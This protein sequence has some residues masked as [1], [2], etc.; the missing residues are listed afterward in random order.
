[1]SCQRSDLFLLYV[2]KK[3]TVDNATTKVAVSATPHS[4][5]ATISN[6]V[7]SSLGKAAA[8]V[9]INEIQVKAL[10]VVMPKVM[11]IPVL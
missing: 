4:T 7:P 9:T 5:I 1:M 2:I 10:I 3:K 8:T 11:L 6:N